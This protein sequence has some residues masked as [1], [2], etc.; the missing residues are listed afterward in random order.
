MLEFWI[1][2]RLPDT[3]YFEKGTLFLWGKNYCVR[4]ESGG[5]E[6]AVVGRNSF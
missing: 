6:E 5:K 2:L 3:T 4:W 1:Q